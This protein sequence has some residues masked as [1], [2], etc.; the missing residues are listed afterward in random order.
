MS[1][2]KRKDLSPATCKGRFGAHIRGLVDRAGLT[3]GELHRHLAQRGFRI[4][5]SG[6]R[7]WLRGEAFPTVEV[8]ELLAGILGLTDYRHIL[9]PPVKA[10]SK[11]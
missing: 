3:V 1:P 9:P 6:I 4:T 5:E 11:R 8:L 7:K 10:P 2:R